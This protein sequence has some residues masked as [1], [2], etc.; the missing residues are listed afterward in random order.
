M[1][2]ETNKVLSVLKGKVITVLHSYPQI[3]TPLSVTP[4]HGYDI[5][6]PVFNSF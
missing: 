5:L 4:H 2:T 6:S 3:A 1:I